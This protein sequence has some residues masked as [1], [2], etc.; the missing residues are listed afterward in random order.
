MEAFYLRRDPT[1]GLGRW[2]PGATDPLRGGS[3][4]RASEAGRKVVHCRGGR[5]GATSYLEYR[6]GTAPGIVAVLYPQWGWL[7]SAAV[8]SEYQK[9]RSA[10]PVSPGTRTGAPGVALVRGETQEA[11]QAGYSRV[12]TLTAWA[13]GRAPA[14]S[15]AEA[16]ASEGQA[17]GEPRR[18]GRWDHSTRTTSASCG[19]SH[20]RLTARIYRAVRRR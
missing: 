5:D 19:G 18:P 6:A 2:P 17:A 11:P 8:A 9:V 13:M 3:A 12:G 20:I 1:A 15:S 4:G 10:D 7:R 16:L 14:S